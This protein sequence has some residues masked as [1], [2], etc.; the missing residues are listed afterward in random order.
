MM[1]YDTLRGLDY[2]LARP[3]VDTARV[4]TLGMSMGSTMAWWVAA[5]DPRIKLAKDF[6]A[7]APQ[8]EQEDREAKD[9]LARQ[10]KL[11][12]HRLELEEMEQRLDDRVTRDWEGM[13]VE[14]RERRQKAA[15]DE[16]KVHSRWKLIGDAQRQSDLLV[17]ARAQLKRELRAASEQEGAGA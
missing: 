10:T 12:Q 16:L 13:T 8:R 9:E 5:L 4:G 1:V 14:D 6:A 17:A 2:L 7:T 3:E 15:R 11:Q